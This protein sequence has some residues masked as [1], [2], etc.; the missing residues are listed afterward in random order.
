MGAPAGVPHHITVALHRHCGVVVGQVKQGAGAAHGQRVPG[1]QAEELEAGLPLHWRSLV[2]R[3]HTSA[4]VLP[5]V[6]VVPGVPPASISKVPALS[7]R[8][9]GRELIR[10]PAACMATLIRLQL[11]AA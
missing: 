9:G 7:R 10:I 1:I 8:Q 2:S 6:H 11:N 4:R 3:A 5:T